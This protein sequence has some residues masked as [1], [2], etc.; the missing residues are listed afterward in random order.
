MNADSLTEERI[1]DVGFD[2]IPDNLSLGM[3][4]HVTI[5]L[6]GV[7]QADWLPAAAIVYRQGKPGVWRIEGDKVHFAPLRIGIRTL[8]GKV[9]VLEGLSPQDEVALYPK[10]PLEEETRIRV[11]QRNAS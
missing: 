8:D 10:K 7:E 1:V 11:D 2:R 5:R 4:A 3:L 9:Q 6:P